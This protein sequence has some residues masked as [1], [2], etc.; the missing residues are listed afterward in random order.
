MQPIWTSLP[1]LFSAG[2]EFIVSISFS[3]LFQHKH[4]R[5]KDKN[6]GVE[7]DEEQKQKKVKNNYVRI[8]IRLAFIKQIPLLQEK[9]IDENG[10]KAQMSNGH[11]QHDADTV[12]DPNDNDD[13]D[14]HEYEDDVDLEYSKEG[15]DKSDDEEEDI[16]RRK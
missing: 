4:E 2:F 10:D 6:K 12:T 9:Q 13:Y 14:G 16:V 3:Y 15:N 8:L 7:K 1:G 11:S 5:K